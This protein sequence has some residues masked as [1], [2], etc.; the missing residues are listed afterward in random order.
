MYLACSGFS[1]AIS[2]SISDGAYGSTLD[3]PLSS[4]TAARNGERVAGNAGE[5]AVKGVLDVGSEKEGDARSD[6]R[7]NEAN[8]T[9]KAAKGELARRTTADSCSG[10][11][12]V[13][14]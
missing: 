1:C 3:I 14:R 13:W 12:V 11:R 6:A 4:L 9:G 5:E 7:S 2:A 10:G 8:S